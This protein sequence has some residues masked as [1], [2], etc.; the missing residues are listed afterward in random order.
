MYRTMIKT[1]TPILTGLFIVAM[2]FIA[3]GLEADENG[4][5]IEVNGLYRGDGDCKDYDY[6][7]QAE[8]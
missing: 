8:P 3:I 1:M 5:G 6:L 7:S 4:A 2:V